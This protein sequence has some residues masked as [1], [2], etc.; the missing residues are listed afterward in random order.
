[1]GLLI[2][3][4]P[5]IQPGELLSNAVDC[6]GGDVVRITMA[7]HWTPANLSFQISTDGVGFNDLFDVDGEEVVLPV[8][9]GVAVP[10]NREWA[11]FWNFIKFRSGTR[12]Y[13]VI[14]TPD[15]REF[16]ITLNV[17]DAVLAGASKKK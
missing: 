1:M 16:A 13:P 9:P 5:I 15:Q 17:P 2:I 4:G 6:S 14:Q 10:I 7:F 11:K 12:E 8:V 3:N